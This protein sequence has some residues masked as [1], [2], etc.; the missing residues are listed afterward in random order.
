MKGGL[1]V[2]V[3]WTLTLCSRVYFDKAGLYRNSV[4]TNQDGVGEL[5]FVLSLLRLN[6]VRVTM[7]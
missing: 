4:K 2:K 1:R 3:V 7:S 5:Y 6:G